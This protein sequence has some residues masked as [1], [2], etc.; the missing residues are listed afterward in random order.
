VLVYSPTERKKHSQC[1]W[2]KKIEQIIRR[3]DRSPN[4]E[5]RNAIRTSA[6]KSTIRSDWH[7]GKILENLGLKKETTLKKVFE[8]VF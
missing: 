6:S 7:D 5:L 2:K 4:P 8:S 3:A 1:L